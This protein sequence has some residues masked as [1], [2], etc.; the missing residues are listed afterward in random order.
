METNNKV[1]LILAIGVV[2]ILG[3]VVVGE[4]FMSH[5]QSD[6]VSAEIIMLVDK[7]IMALVASIAGYLGGTRNRDKS[8]EPEQQPTD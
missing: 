5:N 7:S 6:Q 1:V 2:T 4:L 3:I 8:D